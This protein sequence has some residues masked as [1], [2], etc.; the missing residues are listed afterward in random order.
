MGQEKERDARLHSL[1]GYQVDAELMSNAPD[2]V[3]LHCLPAHRGEEV[4]DD[5]L[6]SAASRVW[7]QA[8]NRMHSARGYLAFA[9][10]ED[11]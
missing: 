2:A 1:S 5:V 8:E 10:G 9:L 7:K 3:F 4:T 11:R 6:D